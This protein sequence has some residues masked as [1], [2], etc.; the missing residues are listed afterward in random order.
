LNAGGALLVHDASELAVACR[1]LLS[2]A[3]RRRYMGSQALAFVK[4]G[5]GALQRV[6]TLLSGLLETSEAN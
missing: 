3:G 5:Q 2:D 1:A 4:A 6:E